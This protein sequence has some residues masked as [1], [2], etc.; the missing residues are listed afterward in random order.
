MTMPVER[1]RAPLRAGGFLIEF[2]RD[3]RLPLDVRRSTVAIARHFRPLKTLR[4]CPVPIPD[5]ARC[6]V[7]DAARNTL[8]GQRL[9]IRSAP[10]FH[11]IEIA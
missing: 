1:T 9:S 11:A 4:P 10:L 6:W 5:Q 7:D 3:K 2:A 8:M